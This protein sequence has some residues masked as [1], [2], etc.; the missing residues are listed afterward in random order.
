[1]SLALLLLSLLPI[2]F[3]TLIVIVMWRRKQHVVYP[4]FWGYLCFQV[5]WLA[6][7]FICKAISY[8]AFFYTYWIFS[9]LN[10]IFQLLLLRDIFSRTLRKY[11]QIERF[12]RF[13]FEIALLGSCATAVVA[14]LLGNRVHTVS[15][16]IVTAEL[17]MSAVE[18]S[19]F[20]FVAT[21]AIV[22]GIKWKSAICGMA[23]G[24]G[25]LGTLDV[26]AFI[27]MIYSASLSRHVTIASWVNTVG[28]DFAIGVFSFYFLPT[29]QEIAVPKQ[30]RR[31]LLDWA[32]SMRGSLPR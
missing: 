7:E 5:A 15:Q 9:F 12:R 30:V 25:V 3:L 32:E 8:K 27:I 28:Y 4:I 17:V 18:V 29:R 23:A 22:L 21:S 10:L 31:E 14:V 13:L 11:P 16:M 26:A 1:M 20:I 6:T 19:L 2:P 24:L